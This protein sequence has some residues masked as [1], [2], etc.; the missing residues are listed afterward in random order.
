[1]THIIL[2]DLNNAKNLLETLFYGNTTLY[3]G[4]YGSIRLHG[5]VRGS[6]RLDGTMRDNTEQQ[7]QD[8]ELRPFC[9]LCLAACYSI[10][11]P[12]EV[13]ERVA[14]DMLSQ[15]HEMTS[16]PENNSSSVAVSIGLLGASASA[17]GFAGGL[18]NEKEKKVCIL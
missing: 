9:G 2:L 7:F 10:T 16:P 8:F 12:G 4:K 11:R 6:R 5:S 3:T 1:M 17:F 14:L 15:I 13:G 18:G